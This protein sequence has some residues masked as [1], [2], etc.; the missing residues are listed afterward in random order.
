MGKV[1]DSLAT[2]NA[3]NAL[4]VKVSEWLGATD[5]T[6]IW[7]TCATCHY[8]N[9]ETAFCAKYKRVPPVAVIAGSV[10]CPGYSD[11]EEIPF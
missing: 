1:R 2:Q 10:E 5:P 9:N 8:S 7:E 6:S 3:A 11:G 4:A